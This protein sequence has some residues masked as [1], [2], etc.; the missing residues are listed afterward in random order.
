[1]QSNTISVFFVS[2]ATLISWFLS[3]LYHPLM[4][5]YLTIEEFWKFESL[6][7]LLNIFL[8]MI[9]ALGLFYTKEVSKNIENLEF[10]KSFR[11]SSIQLIT[12][13]SLWL[14]WV[15]IIMSP[16][17]S[18]YLKIPFY[19]F[20][21]LGLTII[22]SFYAVINNAYFQW[23]RKFEYIAAII[24]FSSV[25]KLCIWFIWVFLWFH[26]F[27]A[28]AWVILSQIAMF[29]IWNFYLNKFFNS[30]LK[31]NKSSNTSSPLSSLLSW[32]TSTSSS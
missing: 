8:V 5:R 22:Y 12:Y 13:L 20:L 15:L 9:I 16:L 17:L 30:S 31:K 28:L 29:Y 4:I 6:L 18:L 32:W 14:C 10:S 24:S 11:R 7:S 26:I 23:L 25:L 19:Y 2:W 27:W 21:P 1:M 3:Y